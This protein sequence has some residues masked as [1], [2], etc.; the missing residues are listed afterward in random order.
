MTPG[1]LAR[2]HRRA[3][4]SRKGPS[5]QEASLPPKHQAYKPLISDFQPPEPR[6]IDTCLWSEPPRP[7]AAGDPLPRFLELP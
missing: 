7:N 3:G 1:A 2:P 4:H 6:E 5:G